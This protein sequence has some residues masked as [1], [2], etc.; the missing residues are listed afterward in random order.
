LIRPLRI[1]F[2]RI[3]HVPG[4]AAVAL[5]SVRDALAEALMEPGGVVVLL[6]VGQDGAQMLLVQDEDPV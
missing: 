6:V 5:G 3:W 1:G 2:R 4:S